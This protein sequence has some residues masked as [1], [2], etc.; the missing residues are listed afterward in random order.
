MLPIPVTRQKEDSGSWHL[1]GV[2]I[3]FDNIWMWIHPSSKPQKL[4]D[5]GEALLTSFQCA[6]LQTRMIIINTSL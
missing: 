2:G 5:L 3:G 4:G 1:I 6:C